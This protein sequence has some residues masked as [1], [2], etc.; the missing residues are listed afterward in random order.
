M[1]GKAAYT[2]QTI[3]KYTKGREEPHPPPP[4][5]P[6]LTTRPSRHSPEGAVKSGA[7]W[8][9]DTKDY[10][11]SQLGLGRYAIFKAVLLLVNCGGWLT[12][13]WRR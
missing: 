2:F 12:N 4:N 3:I 9:M 13:D 1:N 6:S 8:E 5:N 11:C 10:G 7:C